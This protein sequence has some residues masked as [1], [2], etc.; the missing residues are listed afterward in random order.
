MLVLTRKLKQ[1]IKIG[2]DITITLTDIHSLGRAQIGIEAPEDLDIV[3]EELANV[4]RGRRN[5]PKILKLVENPSLLDS[6]DSNH[7]PF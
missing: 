6:E 1:R 2:P 3:R 7:V 4:W 5:N